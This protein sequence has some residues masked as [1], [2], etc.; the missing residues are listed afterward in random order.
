MR[1]YEADA[2]AFADAAA[3]LEPAVAGAV[4]PHLHDTDASIGEAERLAVLRA[5]DILDTPPEKAFD[6]LALA[7]AKI[8]GV[9]IAAVSLVDD[10]RQWFKA[11]IGLEASETPRSVSFCNHAM[12]R[13]SLYVV[14]DASLDPLFADSALVTGEPKI[15]FYAGAAIRSPEGAP[16]GALCVISPVARPEGLTEEQ[17]MVLR[18]LANQVE[19]QLKLRQILQA[20]HALTHQQA[21]EIASSQDREER[22][23]KALASADIGWWDW[24]L[25][26]D[27]VF[28]N[29]E[30][31]RMLGFS[32]DEAA[33]GVSMECF[34]SNI[35][36]GDRAVLRD[37]V[38]DA[39]RTGEVFVE[40]YRVLRPDGEAIWISARGRALKGPDGRTL[41]FPGVAIEITEQK[42]TEDR[43]R[44]ADMGRELALDAARL[45]R[46]DHKPNTGERFYDVR[47]LQL[48][49]LTS[50]AAGDFTR[51]MGQVH[52]Q[53]R[54]RIEAARDRVMDA[55]RS[56]LYRETFR[57]ILDSGEER[58]LSAV[59]R[60]Q[61]TDGVCTRF[62]GV[63]EDVT[64]TI[65]AESHRRLLVNELN[66]RVKNTLTLMQSMV[67][68]T[69]RSSTDTGEA[70]LKL[71]ARIQAFGR[72]HDQLTASNWS[73]AYVDEVVDGVI[74]SLS[75][76]PERVEIK[77]PPARLGPQ[78]ALQLALAL[79]E[80]ATNALKYGALSNDTG[81]IRLVWTLDLV[82]G[83]L[84]FSLSW[85]E[86][87]GPTVHPPTRKGFG[88]QLIE[89]A[90]AAAFGGKVSLDYDPG[91][92]RWSVTAPYLGLAESGR[93]P[94]SLPVGP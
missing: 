68:S 6:E 76:P 74:S 71:N 30:M 69:L 92:L 4:F 3:W 72:A 24:D 23:L 1:L 93:A 80:L 44:D 79:H 70:R 22:L 21:A 15:R 87:G 42:R 11:R 58:W 83:G 17:A 10:A 7:A 37:A 94:A 54:D 86:R 45:G 89:R 56:G 73:A 84:V 14:P 85:T 90:T 55:R 39:V 33:K 64:E 16:L 57:L 47:A 13:D 51:V 77:G 2:A 38:D 91:G 82:E 25:P 9:P 52:P 34:F 62:L 41:S 46:W 50:N 19:A 61:F 31:G 60:T 65:R 40:D 36:P 88:T 67:D 27:K 49:G 26:S 81:R 12:W 32:A 29:G 43:V 20:Q 28:A 59:G 53:D 48:L 66:H 8:C 5:M 35:H 63:I 18:V 78:P 75:L